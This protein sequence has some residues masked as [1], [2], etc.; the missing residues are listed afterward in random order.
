MLK[1]LYKVIDESIENFSLAFL[2]L[3]VQNHLNQIQQKDRKKQSIYA[4]FLLNKLVN[5][6]FHKNLSDYTFHYNEN[7][8][9][10]FKEFFVSLSHSFDV[11]AVGLSDKE[12]GIDIEKKRPLPQME[13]LKE[14]LC[15]SK[16][17]TDDE[18]FFAFT[19]VESVVKAKGLK[20]GYHLDK[21]NLKLD[22]T[23]SKKIEIENQIFYLSYYSKNEIVEIGGNV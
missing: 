11:C 15:G 17:I 4:W 5:Q 8:K 19:K 7:G 23:K 21:I 16:Q 1:I 12:V 9:P 22:N 6:T 13:A 18:F 10:E 20:L 3:E 2:P 14:R